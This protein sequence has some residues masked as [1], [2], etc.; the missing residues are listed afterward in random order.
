MLG[1]N[2]TKKLKMAY[3]GEGILAAKAK[4][5]EAITDE[6]R[7]LSEA[8]IQTMYDH[9]GVGLAGNQIGLPLQI[10]VL[11]VGTPED[12]DGNPL[13]PS[14]PGEVMLLPKMPLTLINPQITAY[15]EEICDY[16]EGC[17]SVPK[18]YANVKRP[19]SVTLK[20]QLLD[21]SE[22]TVECG[23]FLAR[24]LQHE[25]DH[26]NGIVFV[27]KAEEEDYQKISGGLE[28]LIRKNGPRGFKVKRLV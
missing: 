26:L 17:L 24:A 23:G 9:N 16:T 15:S 18:L 20:T 5:V 14:S 22:I 11:D 13:P 10:V 21:G 3:L 7:E 12:E 19:C 4:R 27:Q 2:K 6:I 8:M 25:I 1:R 28:K